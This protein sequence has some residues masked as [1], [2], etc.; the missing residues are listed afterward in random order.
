MSSPPSRPPSLAPPDDPHPHARLPTR[1]SPRPPPAG[2]PRLPRTAILRAN[3]GVRLSS[4]PAAASS[5]QAPR[6]S[7]SPRTPP[8]HRPLRTGQRD[9]AA[10]TQVSGS[11]LPGL[12]MAPAAGHPLPAPAAVLSSRRQPAAGQ[13]E[14]TPAQPTAAATRSRRCPAPSTGRAGGTP[15]PPISAP[16]PARAAPRPRR[17][18]GAL[19]GAAHWGAARGGR[20][21]AGTARGRGGRR[22]VPPRAAT[23]WCGPAGLLWALALNA[24]TSPAGR[25]SSRAA[26]RA[27][28]C[29]GVG[30]AAGR[31]GL[32]RW[33]GHLRSRGK[34]P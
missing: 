10:V 7:P 31:S 9:A 27:S 1:H 8:I 6:G 5:A 22:S 14:E 26:A 15:A 33:P 23:R 20:G 16:R 11:R 18:P 3:R 25:A 29:G 21:W 13:R 32:G 34:F 17:V 19:R 24:T 4:Q 28:E 30:A 2:L 12:A